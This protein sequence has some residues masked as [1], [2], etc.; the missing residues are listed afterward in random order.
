MTG[1]WRLGVGSRGDSPRLDRLAPLDLI[2]GSN[3]PMIS[4]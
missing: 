3:R 4:G 2:L 1:A